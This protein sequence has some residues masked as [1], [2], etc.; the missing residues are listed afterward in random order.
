[1]QDHLYA[2]NSSYISWEAVS[3]VFRTKES[4]QENGTE[5]GGEAFG[6]SS[7]ATVTEGDAQAIISERV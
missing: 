5:R 4:C 6:Y 2:C 1:M 7:T 3:N